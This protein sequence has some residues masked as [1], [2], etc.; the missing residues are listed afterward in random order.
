MLLWGWCAVTATLALLLPF[1][2]LDICISLPSA[3]LIALAGGPIFRFASEKPSCL[4]CS[5]FVDESRRERTGLRVR[6]H[7]RSDGA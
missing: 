3:M 1:Y 4:V 2:F 5:A 6:A 7:R